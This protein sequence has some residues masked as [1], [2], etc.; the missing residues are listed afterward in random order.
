MK[1]QITFP[2]VYFKIV[3]ADKSSAATLLLGG[4]GYFSPPL[5]ES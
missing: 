5:P 4:L 3:L 1:L 2:Y